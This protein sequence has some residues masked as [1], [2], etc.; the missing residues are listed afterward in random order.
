MAPVESQAKVVDR[1]P[2]DQQ[3]IQNYCDEFLR[4]SAALPPGIYQ[5]ALLRRV[6][7]VLDLLEAWQN[8]RRPFASEEV[9]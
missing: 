7:C 4:V 3:W 6:E 8:R 2:I 1:S 5:D 9:R